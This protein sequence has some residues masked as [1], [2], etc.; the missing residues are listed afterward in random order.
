MKGVMEKC[1]FCVQ[2]LRTAK[3]EAK[4]EGRMVKDGEVLTA[5]QQ[6]CPA[7][8]IEFGNY[9][10]HDSKVYHA[11]HDARAYRA[12]DAHLQTKPGISYLKRVVLHGK[13]HA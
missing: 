12:L 3:D 4:D 9:S 10:D 7:H 1:T 11:A 6:A 2:R 5:C 8:A 13:E